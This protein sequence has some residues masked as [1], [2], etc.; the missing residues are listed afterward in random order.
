MSTIKSAVTLTVCMIT[1]TCYSQ[2]FHGIVFT[3]TNDK[4]IGNS[5]TKNTQNIQALMLDISTQLNFKANIS[6]Y[7]GQSYTYE[8]LDSVLKSLKTDAGD[9][10]FFYLNSHGYKS[11]TSSNFPRIS[12]K[13]KSARGFLVST[14]TINA[15]LISQSTNPQSIITVIQSCNR[16]TSSSPDLPLTTKGFTDFSEQNFKKLFL[17]GLNVMVTSSQRGK[18]SIATSKGSHFSLS[19][20]KALREDCQ[21]ENPSTVTWESVLENAKK[22]SLS[23]NR[24]RYPVWNI[25]PL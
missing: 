6:V 16:I 4:T 15:R 19:F 25:K 3:N 14:D 24:K 18:T 5:A 13:S 1:F 20:I 17:S 12:I 23:L 11:S 21:N 22:Y 8:K 7:N 10:I 9:V 2:T